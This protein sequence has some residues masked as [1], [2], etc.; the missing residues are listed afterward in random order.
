MGVNARGERGETAL[1]TATRAGDTEAV[2]SLLAH[3]V[4]PFIE[5]FTR[6]TAI[7]YARGNPVMEQLFAEKLGVGVGDLFLR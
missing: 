5:D 7:D 1:I 4:D 2:R 3:D 6:A